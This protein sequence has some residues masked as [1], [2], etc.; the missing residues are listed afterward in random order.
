MDATGS[1]MTGTCATRPTSTAAT[2]TTRASSSGARATRSA[3]RPPPAEPPSCRGWWTSSTRRTRRARSPAPATDR[4]HPC[5]VIWSA[6][7]EISEQTTAGGAAVLQGLVD[8]FHKEDPT[9]PVTCACDKA[10]AEPDS[11][12]PEFMALQ[13]VAGYNY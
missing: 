7:N 4:N 12:T 8:I 5:V 13:D 9:R 2:G 1:W 3:S 11:A 6:G 10:Y